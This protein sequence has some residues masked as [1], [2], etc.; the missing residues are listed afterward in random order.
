MTYIY[1]IDPDGRGDNY[2]E[3]FNDNNIS[4]HNVGGWVITLSK[5]EL[6]TYVKTCGSFIIQPYN[7]NQ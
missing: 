5:Q 4:P 1:E 7:I 2:Y 3:V 6:N